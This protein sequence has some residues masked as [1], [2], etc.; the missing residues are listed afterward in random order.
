MPDELPITD[1]DLCGMIGN[2]LENAITACRS[3]EKDK[4][5]IQFT[6][7]TLNDA[8]LCIV[9]TNSFDGNVRQS[10]GRYLSTHRDGKGTGLLSIAS[11][12]AKYGGAAEFSHKNNEF[13]TDVMIPVA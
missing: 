5:W 3:L 7:L 9:A 12:A 6:A 4:R 13:Y 2:I 10:A 1:I 11:T 8:Q